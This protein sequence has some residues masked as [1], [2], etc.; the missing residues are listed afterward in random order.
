MRKKIGYDLSEMDGY[1]LTI[2]E[3]ESKKNMKS[4]EMRKMI[5]K[6]VPMKVMTF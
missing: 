4:K 2:K 5:N 1:T 6:Y 3:K